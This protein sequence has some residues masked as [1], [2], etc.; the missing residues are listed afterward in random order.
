M[1]VGLWGGEGDQHFS[2]SVFYRRVFFLTPS[3]VRKYQT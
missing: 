1:V 2:L 3:R